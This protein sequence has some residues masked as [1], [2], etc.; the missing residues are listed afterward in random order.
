MAKGEDLDEI[1]VI[2]VGEP[3]T[4][5]TCLINVA[6][7]NDFIENTDSTIMSTYMTKK[8]VIN[9]KEYILNLWDTA[10]QE[11][12]RSMTKIFTKNSK[13]VIFVYAI[14]SKASFEE[15]KSYWI[16]T[17]QEILGDE[18][19]MGIAGNKSDLYLDEQV[20]EEE[21]RDYANSIGIKYK[22][23]SAKEDPIR[24]SNFIEELVDEFLTKK[25][26]DAKKD[27]VNINNPKKLKGG[28]C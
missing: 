27:N 22:L 24:F 16:K 17:L 10:G 20:K 2:L 7:G 1:K 4:G 14:N 25:G 18:A 11:K 12:Y 19:I 28:C 9:N 3:G 21:V 23:V 26:I 15:M 13:I 6:T 5:K 8:I